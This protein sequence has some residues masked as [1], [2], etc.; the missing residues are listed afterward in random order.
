MDIPLEWEGN[1]P[2]EQLSGVCMVIGGSN[3]GK[4]TFARYAY[5]RLCQIGRRA[6]Y[7]DGDPGQS[8]LGPPTTITIARS[9]KEGD[10]AFPPTGNAW[11]SFIGST[12]PYG[13]MLPMVVGASRLAS[14]VQRDGADVIIHDT[15][16]LIDQQAG[17][18]LKLALIDLL[19]PS[20]VIAIQEKHELDPLLIPLRRSKRTQL[21]ELAPSEAVRSRSMDVR[22]QHRAE[23]Y[24]AYFSGALPVIIPWTRLA[25]FPEPHFPPRRLVA[26]EDREG[27]CLGLGIVL[28]GSQPGRSL[29]LLTPYREIDNIDAL[30][31]GDILLDPQTFRDERTDIFK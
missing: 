1:I 3:L 4:S 14:A 29:A 18:G 28:E 13:H 16:G 25:V 17:M 19:K 23:Q 5:Q 7:L 10:D 21:I 6:A 20:H 11:R 12:T 22:Q 26:F 15:C 31:V 8:Q 2:W 30:R 27:F 9:Q 24:A